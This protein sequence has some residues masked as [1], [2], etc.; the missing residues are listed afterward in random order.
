[1]VISEYRPSPRNIDNLGIAAKNDFQ[2]KI[3]FFMVISKYRN[4]PRNIDSLRITAKNNFFKVISKYRPFPRNVDSLGITAKKRLFR[5]K[6]FFSRCFQNI[7][8]FSEVLIVY[9]IQPKTIFQAKINFFMVIS[10][11]CPLP[12]NID[13][14]GITVQA[15]Q[16]KNNFLG[17]NQFFQGD[18]KI[19]SFSLKC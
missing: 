1:M 3:N 4:F 5:Q 14:I 12:R 15:L 7:V 2:T 13:N 6:S 8:L 18:L 10:K 19:S 16:P 11:Y 17:K 9:E